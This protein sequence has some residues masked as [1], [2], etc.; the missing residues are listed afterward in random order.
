MGLEVVDAIQSVRTNYDDRPLEDVQ[1]LKAT[2]LEGTKNIG[3]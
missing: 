3:D 2:V 1:I